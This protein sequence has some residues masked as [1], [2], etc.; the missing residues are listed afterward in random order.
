MVVAK[1]GAA[2]ACAWSRSLAVA[3]GIGFS[4]FSNG[5]L[6]A[7][8]G[9]LGGSLDFGCG[10][11]PGLGTSDLAL[12]RLDGK[13]GACVWSKSFGAAGASVSGNVTVSAID[14]AVTFGTV[15]G[16]AVDFG[17]GPIS[18]SKYVLELDGSGAYRYQDGAAFEQHALD[19]CGDVHLAQSC[20]T[21]ASGN[22]GVTVTKLAP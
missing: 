13:T 14:Y 11:M 5:D 20:A 9:I 19:T 7:S 3:T 17:G 1:L 2:G 4:P 16:A 15:S 6:A 22:P 12:A 21:C 10:P 18:S 8:T